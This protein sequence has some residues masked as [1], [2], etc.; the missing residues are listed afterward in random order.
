VSHTEQRSEKL[1]DRWLR[2]VFSDT[3]SGQ[4]TKIWGEFD[5]TGFTA[6]EA[7]LTRYGRAFFS[8]RKVLQIKEQEITL[9]FF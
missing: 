8:K 9:V 6:A 2:S 1:A 4:T 5:R 7:S 3:S